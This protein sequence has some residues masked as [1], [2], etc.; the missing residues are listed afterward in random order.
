LST[1]AG[2]YHADLTIDLSPGG[3]RNIVTEDDAFAFD[4]GT[5]FVHSQHEDCATH[6]LRIDTP[7]QV[8]GGT[9]AF[10]GASGSGREFSS[11]NAPT[12][13]YEGTISF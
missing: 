7:F 9:G 3:S 6:G 2:S 13:V 4:N 11:V 5:I 8:T 12:I 1:G 10:D